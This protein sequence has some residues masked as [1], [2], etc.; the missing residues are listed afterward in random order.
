M[1]L[2]V[3]INATVVVFPPP[4]LPVERLKTDEFCPMCDKSL[5]YVKGPKVICSHC[6]EFWP[7]ETTSKPV[8]AFRGDA[9]AL[10]GTENDMSRASKSRKDTLKKASAVDALIAEKKAE[11]GKDSLLAPKPDKKVLEP[12]APTPKKSEELLASKLTFV[13]GKARESSGTGKIAAAFGKGRKV[14]DVVAEQVKCFER[15]HKGNEGVDDAMILYFVKEAKKV[16][17][18][19]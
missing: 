5:F 4:L 9:T 12:K 2:Q 13:A 18:L 6:A 3:T 1:N 15:G 16:G 14:S 7:I 10:S 11:K 8:S 17:A 19:I